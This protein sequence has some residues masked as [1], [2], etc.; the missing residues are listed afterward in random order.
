MSHY[1]VGNTRSTYVP[2]GDGI[3]WDQVHPP[4]VKPGQ[5]IFAK[6]HFEEVQ[7]AIGLIFLGTQAQKENAQ[8][9]SENGLF[10]IVD[11]KKVRYS[12]CNPRF[13]HQND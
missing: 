11:R 1:T 6:G 4:R 2:K 3:S 10:Y 5:C 7:E 12:G 8:K 9:N 13:D